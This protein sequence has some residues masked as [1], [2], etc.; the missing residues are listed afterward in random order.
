MNKNEIKE[1]MMK[2]VLESFF[3]IEDYYISSVV[4]DFRNERCERKNIAYR[5]NKK[6]AIRV[7]ERGMGGDMDFNWKERRKIRAFYKIMGT[8]QGLVNRFKAIAETEKNLIMH[9]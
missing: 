1:Q 7:V 3:P 6:T 5:S 9:I 2:K 8:Y 4:D